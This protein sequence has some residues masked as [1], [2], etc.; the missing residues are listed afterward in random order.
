MASEEYA[1][2]TCSRGVVPRPRL[3]RRGIAPNQR[4]RARSSD[5]KLAQRPPKQHTL[6][7]SAPLHARSPI[8]QQ[9]LARP[10][11]RRHLASLSL[12]RGRRGQYGVSVA[13]CPVWRFANS[14]ASRTKEKNT[15]GVP[16]RIKILLPCTRSD[17]SGIFGLGLSPL[18]SAPKKSGACLLHRANR[19]VS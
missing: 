8:S 10:L 9:P 5:G 12:P 1:A 15:A 3:Y 16:P 18:T 17:Y 13:R 7:S 14:G 19:F 2:I 4:E 6:I 11:H